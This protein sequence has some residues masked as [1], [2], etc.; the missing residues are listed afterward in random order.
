MFR[1]EGR[2]PLAKAGVRGPSA[3]SLPFALDSCFRKNDEPGI[4]E[5]GLNWL[6]PSAL[7]TGPV[8]DDAFTSFAGVAQAFGDFP[9]SRPPPA[10]ILALA[11]LF[12]AVVGDPRWPWKVLPHPVVLI[13][14]PIGFL[15]RRLNRADRAPG[16]RLVR[17][18]ITVAV[19]VGLALAAGIGLERLFDGRAWGW[20]AEAV[21]VGVLLAA[22]SLHDRVRRVGEALREN[23]LEGARRAIAHI[24]S[25]DPRGL[26][27]H[28][29]ARAA[30]ESLSE[31][32][33][34]G[35]VAPL[36]W[37][38]IFGLPGIF[39]YK[40]VN[41]LDSMIGYRTDTYRDFG[42]A[43]AKLDDIANWAPARLSALAVFLAACFTPTAYP[44]EAVHTALK[45]A[46]SHKS[47]NAGWPE[48]AFAGALKIALGGPRNYP[49]GE[50]VGV[51]IGKDNRAR[52][53]P[54]DIDRA[55]ALYAV[56]NALIW[57]AVMT[58]GLVA[59]L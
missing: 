12:D 46:K 17:G 59:V 2:P 36:F 6:R 51:W 8:M 25:R 43:A 30:I 5:R 13:G 18:L 53:D 47:P 41:T 3:S 58:G 40:A 57:F 48:A 27:R 26:D 56:A 38:L 55:R 23:G 16:D 35:V 44:I 1:M 45:E 19:V 31:N 33:S 39:G 10:L 32:F 50:T 28:A 7:E 54:R 37:Y 11:M 22:R 52:L 34:D 20:I 49:G 15:D 29:V 24:V 9:P 4:L 42:F 14:K 21:L